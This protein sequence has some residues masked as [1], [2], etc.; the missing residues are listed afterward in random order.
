[1][2]VAEEESEQAVGDV[3]I[4]LA[5]RH[6]SQDLPFPCRELRQESRGRSKP[7]SNLQCR[8]LRSDRR[9]TVPR[10]AA[11]EG[12]KS[13]VSQVVPAPGD[14]GRAGSGLV[15]PRC[16][17]KQM[18][19]VAVSGDSLQ[20]AIADF[21]GL[22]AT[23]E[24]E[25]QGTIAT[26]LLGEEIDVPEIQLACATGAQLTKWRASARRGASTRQH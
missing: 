5:C 22:F 1:M 20:H 8:D 26:E 6:Q 3:A 11:D 10:K 17:S 16:G 15:E 9:G 19:A 13:L 23:K 2:T 14:K 25:Q 21:A 12:R 7:A 18:H 24:L 4:A